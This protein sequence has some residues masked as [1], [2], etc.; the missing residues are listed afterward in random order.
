MQLR[1]HL[2]DCRMILKT[3]AGEGLGTRLDYHHVYGCVYMTFC[4]LDQ[5]AWH[6]TAVA[7]LLL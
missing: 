6:P 1:H 4:Q 2:Y 7:L 3:R 5:P